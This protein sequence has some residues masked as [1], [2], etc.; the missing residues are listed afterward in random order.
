MKVIVGIA[1]TDERTSQLK[2]TI[3]SLYN[4]VDKICV[5]NNSKNKI[6][7]TD[8]GKF[9]ILKQYTEPIYYF[10]CDDDII[11][12]SNYIKHTIEQIEKY[13][14]IV[15]Y[16]GRILKGLDLNYYIGHKV[17][18]CKYTT[19]KDERID[20][21]GTGVTAFRTDYFNPIE[22][23]KSEYKRM[24]D[25]VFSLE[26]IN[27]GKNIMQLKHNQ[28][29]LI[30][31]PIPMNKTIAGTSY[32]NCKQQNELANQIYSHPLRNLHNPRLV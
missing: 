31:Q 32:N 24:S 23:Y 16:H 27:Q 26:A 18:N 2:K 6:D 11:Y 8:N 22:I 10:S 30:V 12:P 15:T 13:K 1:T 29:W 21:C 28:N 17:F 20:V 25:L 7:Y 9:Y 3:N 4:Q 14:C 19:L 5:Y